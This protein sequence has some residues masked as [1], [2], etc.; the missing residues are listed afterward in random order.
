MRHH[1]PVPSAEPDAPS[2]AEVRAH[3]RAARSN[4]PEGE[5]Q[6]AALSISGHALELLPRSGGS[7]ACYLSLPTEPG[8]DP[9][10]EAASRLGC[11][12]VAPRITGRDLL[13]IEHRPGDALSPGPM[14]IREPTGAPVDANELATLDVIFTPGLAVDRGGRRLGQGGGY[15]DR[16]LS[17]IPRHAD[18]G[19]L[20][21]IVLF[22]DEVID[23]VPTED[24]DRRVDAALTPSGLTYF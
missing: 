10:I 9:L 5:R 8:T 4:R 7:I 18:G 13:W 6:T 22:D 19:P 21:V 2:K 24:H 23:A 12:I 17:A 20:L 16:V 14:G 15:Y 3:V 11:R 1:G